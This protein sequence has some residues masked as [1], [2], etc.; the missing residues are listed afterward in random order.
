MCILR[1]IQNTLGNSDLS[2]TNKEISQIDICNKKDNSTENLF[3][4][5]LYYKSL[6]KT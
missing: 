2:I 1:V 5:K 4:K 6:I 3:L